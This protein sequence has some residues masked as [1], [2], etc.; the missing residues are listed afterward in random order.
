MVVTV[1]RERIKEDTKLEEG[2]SLFNL[3]PH[4]S[5]FKQNPRP[6]NMAQGSKSSSTLI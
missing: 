3:R 2:M 1:T 4:G 6:R 5:V